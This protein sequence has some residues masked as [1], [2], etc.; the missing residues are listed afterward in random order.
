MAHNKQKVSI[1]LKKAS[2]SLQKVQKIL[3]V[4]SKYVFTLAETLSEY[5]E[6]LDTASLSLKN[7]ST[8]TQKKAVSML[9]SNC[10]YNGKDIDF[11]PSPFV[12]S[13]I[14]NDFFT[15]WQGHSEYFDV[16]HKSS[17]FRRCNMVWQ[18]L[19]RILRHTFSVTSCP[20]HRSA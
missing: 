13:M 6:L 5:L 19:L 2:A 17:C 18:G 3:E 15:S 11:K 7:A 14:N 9:T 8:S 12:L 4:D 10:L 16:F 20:R 1:A